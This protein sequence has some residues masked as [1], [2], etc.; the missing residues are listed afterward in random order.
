MGKG[1]RRS[2]F[3]SQGDGLYAYFNEAD[4]NIW[5]LILETCLSLV[6]YIVIMVETHCLLRVDLISG[7]LS[8]SLE[9][10]SGKQGG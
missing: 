8:K 7:N 9:A 10:T 5:G 4:K 3:I 6:V 1:L 2:K